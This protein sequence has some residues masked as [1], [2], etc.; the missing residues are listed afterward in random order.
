MAD[1]RWD[2][3]LPGE[4]LPRQLRTDYIL[5]EGDEVVVD[6]DAWVVESV[7]VVDDARGTISGVVVVAPPHDPGVISPIT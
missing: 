2:V 7:E 6:D 1:F 5:G 3:H 4:D